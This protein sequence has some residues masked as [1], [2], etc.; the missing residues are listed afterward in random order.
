MTNVL[1]SRYQ[2]H[3]IFC[4]LACANVKVVTVFHHL[5]RTVSVSSGHRQG[6]PP[7]QY[8]ENMHLS[9]AIKHES[10][11]GLLFRQTS[12]TRLTMPPIK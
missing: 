11:R 9:P 10:I 8:L 5:S 4:T 1:P 7:S 12:R 2:R 3:N 6:T